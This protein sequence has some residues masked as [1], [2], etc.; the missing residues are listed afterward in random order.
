MPLVPRP[1]A[2][3]TE[4]IGVVLAK[5]PIPLAD[6]FVRYGDA[7]FE[8]EFLHVAVAQGKTIGEP[9][10]V[11]DDFTGQAMILVALGVRA[12]LPRSRAGCHTPPQQG[13]HG[14]AAPCRGGLQPS[15]AVFKPPRA[16]APAACACNA[17]APLP[18]GT[19][20]GV[21]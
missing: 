15:C 4:L 17:P 12:C 3:M 11:T 7:T 1:R 16:L 8:Q 18:A 2:P 13:D 20:R 6:R 9:D 21:P 5:L 10:A 19:A 14:D